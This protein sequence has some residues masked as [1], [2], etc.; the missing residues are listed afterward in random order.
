MDAIT[1]HKAYYHGRKELYTRFQPLPGRPRYG[2]LAE[3]IRTVR[4]QQ[5]TNKKRRCR[6][7]GSS[8]PETLRS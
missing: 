1:Y 7:R 3:S 4:T 8:R 6:G 2:Q 5:E